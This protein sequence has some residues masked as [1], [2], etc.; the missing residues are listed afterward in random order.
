MPPM[1]NAARPIQS[2]ARNF[3]GEVSWISPHAATLT[4]KQGLALENG[5]I[6][7]LT[8]EL[9]SSNFRHFLNRLNR[10]V[11]GRSAV[12]FGRSVK[13]APVLE[14][15]DAKR[16]HYH[17]IIDCPRADLAESFPELI[18]GAWR[19]TD[20]GYDQFDIQPCEV[21]GWINYMSKFRDKPSYSDAF[22][23]AN[24]HTG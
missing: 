4:L 12:R 14:G 9:A 10:S 19:G 23:W 15:G 6:Q 13:C 20:W 17:A 8:P 22:D 21:I 7:T 1:T 11:F 24:C 2:A 3:L 16:L 18:A 5:S